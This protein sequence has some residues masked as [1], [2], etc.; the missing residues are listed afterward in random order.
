MSVGKEAV[1][2]NAMKAIR[3]HM[4]EEA[5]NELGDR[6]SQDFALVIAAFPIV[7]PAEGDV[8]LVEIEQA[9]VG[10][11]DAM[12]VAREIGQD[13]LGT[14][15]GLF[16]IDDPFDCAQGRE[17]GGKCLRLV[18]TDEIPKE[19]R[20]TG[21][22]CCHQTF[23]EQAPKQ[24]REHVRKKGP[25]LVGNPTLAIRRDTATGNDAVSMRIYAER[26]IMLSPG[27][28]TRHWR[29]RAMTL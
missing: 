27:R 17:S 23:E 1:A 28:G 10:D 26:T 13:L 6:D 24:A 11:R 7:L 19:L 4:E 21:I 3:Q 16:G 25:G 12:S 8:G 18:E 9:I 14:G 22:G 20:L 15:E 5:P 29:D 2:A